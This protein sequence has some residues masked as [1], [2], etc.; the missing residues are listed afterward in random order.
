MATSQLYWVRFLIQSDEQK[1][2]IIKPSNKLEKNL[3]THA[4]DL[5]SGMS[6]C[7]VLVHF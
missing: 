3:T 2:P 5:V 6:K 4:I 7:L 1:L